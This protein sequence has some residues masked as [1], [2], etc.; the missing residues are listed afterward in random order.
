MRF[1]AEDTGGGIQPGSARTSPGG[2]RGVVK[3]RLYC[4]HVRISGEG[5]QKHPGCC[6]TPGNSTHLGFLSGLS[7]V[8]PHTI[9][10][11]VP[12]PVRI[13]PKKHINIEIQA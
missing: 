3:S 1:A 4:T 11:T 10:H 7:L 2:P 6:W 13:Y 5:G 8:S 9:P 12:A